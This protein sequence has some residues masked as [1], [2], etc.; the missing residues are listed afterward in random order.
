MFN[1]NPSSSYPTTPNS[2]NPSSPINYKLQGQSSYT[3]PVRYRLGK[4]IDTLNESKSKF[5][6]IQ[7]VFLDPFQYASDI[8][9][10]DA[11]KQ[12]QLVSRPNIRLLSPPW[13]FE[14]KNE[15][16]LKG[17]KD[18]GLD[19]ILTSRRIKN[20]FINEIDSDKSNSINK[21]LDKGKALL[22]VT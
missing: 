21:I 15:L 10:S 20:N 12:T 8:H 17:G 18:I 14:Y 2:S 4:I 1:S 19:S 6:I 13:F 11:S 9:E 7:P 3:P 16:G 22:K 5:F